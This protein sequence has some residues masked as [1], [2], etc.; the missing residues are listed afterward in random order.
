[1]YVCAHIRMLITVYSVRAN[2]LLIKTSTLMP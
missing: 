2:E 1:M